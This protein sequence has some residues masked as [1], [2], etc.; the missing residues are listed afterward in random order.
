MRLWQLILPL[1][2]SLAA[3]LNVADGFA[4]RR[5]R[6]SRQIRKMVRYLRTL[7][8]NYIGDIDFAQYIEGSIEEITSQLDPFSSYMSAEQ[9]EQ[10][11]SHLTRRIAG[12]GAEFVVARDSVVVLRV[13]DNSPAQLSGLQ[14]LDRIVAID[15][16]SVAGSDSESVIATIQGEPSSTLT[17]TVCRPSEGSVRDVTLRRAVIP[18]QSIPVYYRISD[19]VAYIKLSSFTYNTT[20]DFDDVLARVGDVPTL[21][22]DLCDNGGGLAAPAIDIAGRFLERGSVI[23]T[24]QRRG[25]SHSFKS[26][27]AAY[28]GN[29]ILLVNAM[30][31]SS[32][33]LMVAALQDWDRAV[34]VGSETLGK[35]VGQQTFGFDDGSALLLTT[36]RVV[37]PSGRSVQRPFELGAKDEYYVDLISRLTSDTPSELD[38]LSLP[39]FRTLNSSRVVYG[40]SG[41]Q[42]DVV[43]PRSV[44]PIFDERFNSVLVAMLDKYRASIVAQYPECNDFISDF[45]FDVNDLQLMN[46]YADIVSPLLLPLLVKLRMAISIYPAEQYYPAFNSQLNAT[47]HEAVALAHSPERISAILTAKP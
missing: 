17:L 40:N 31:A 46:D 35:G 43:V 42:P 38:T 30:T 39:K 8:R 22:V 25:S 20:R 44:G 24:M 9:Y 2:L 47:Y 6:P 19:S 7:E 15:S 16:R 29:L 27:G 41:L 37:A 14:P 32:S 1:L 18:Q 3:V 33:E 10:H 12:I 23:C 26:K 34:V 28:D 11:R 4:Q 5:E 13:K 36:L 21:I 45:A